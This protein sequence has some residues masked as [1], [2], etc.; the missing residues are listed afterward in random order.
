MTTCCAIEWRT[1]P[2][3][4]SSTGCASCGNSWVS[5]G[6]SWS[7][8]WAGGFRSSACS[9]RFA[10]MRKRSLRVCVSDEPFRATSAERFPLIPWS[11]LEQP[12]AYCH[13]RPPCVPSG[14]AVPQI[15]RFV[16]LPRVKRLPG[17]A[18][19][20]G[21]RRRVVGPKT[22]S[23]V[24]TVNIPGL[25]KPGNVESVIH[26]GIHDRFRIGATLPQVGGV[27]DAFRGRRQIVLF[28][29]EKD[30]RCLGG[31]HIQIEGVAAR[32]ERNVKGKSLLGA[33]HGFLNRGKG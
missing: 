20:H 24:L 1:A 23:P 3:T 30:D 28:T 19:R 2:R 27:R 7:R 9:T 10:S 33:R 6:S 22:P 13:C 14:D 31:R 15:G 4:W 25:T 5:R 18:S 11:C 8:T 32:V 16:L 12:C 26:A 17:V 29:Q 21:A